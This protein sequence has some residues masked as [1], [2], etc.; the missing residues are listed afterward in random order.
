M[1]SLPER[2]FYT[3]NELQNIWELSESDVTQY[4]MHG[5]LAAHIWLPMM[6]IYEVAEEI[7]G[8]RIIL[9]KSLKHWEGYTPLYTHQCRTLFKTGKVYLRE[10]MCEESHKKLILPESVNSIRVC[11]DDVVILYAERK[12]FESEHNFMS[13]S[14]CRVKIVGRA[15]GAQ[16]LKNYSYFEQGFRKVH[17]EGIDFRFG[18][19]QAS[20]LEQ[21]YDHALEGDPWQNGKQLLEKAG[22]QSFTM[23]NVFKS[24][25][26]W[27]KL[28]ESDERGAYRLQ[29]SFL[30]SIKDP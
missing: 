1:Q 14:N 2:V 5:Y 13:L 18:A 17:H 21:L 7:D 9:T 29:E 27:R 23:Q 6:S 28:I 11:I 12:R 16:R 4:L 19:I 26:H 22:S 30:A 25:P 10:F 15:M 20:V 3:R 24:N 8:A